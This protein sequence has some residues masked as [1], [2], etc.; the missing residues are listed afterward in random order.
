MK[1]KTLLFTSVA[2]A[3]IGVSTLFVTNKEARTQASQVVV[4]TLSIPISM[5]QGGTGNALA[6]LGSGGVVY[7]TPT[8]F[9]VTPTSSIPGAPLISNRNGA[10]PVYGPD[11]NLAYTDSS[12]PYTA[13]QSVTPKTLS[14]CT[15]S[16]AIDGISSNTYLCTLTGNII[17]QNPTVVTPGYAYTFRFQQDGTGSRLL[18]MGSYYTFQSGTPPVL[19]TA[20]NSVDYLR[21]QTITTTEIDCSNLQPG[22]AQTTTLYSMPAPS[23]YTSSLLTVEEQFN[24]ASLDSNWVGWFGNDATNRFNDAGG[25]ASPYSSTSNCGGITNCTGS[26]QQSGSYY[27]PYSYYPTSTITSGTHLMGGGGT[28]TLTAAPSTHFNATGGQLGYTWAGSAISSY[29]HI[30]LPTSGGY[31]QFSAKQP[32]SSNGAQASL[33][34][35]PGTSFPAAPEIDLMQTGYLIGNCTLNCSG[36]G[37]ASVNT[38]QFM[39]FGSTNDAYYTG[40]TDLSAG[41]HIYGLEYIPGVSLKYYLD[42]QLIQTYTTSVPS[43]NYSVIIDLQMM[44]SNTSGYHTVLSGSS[45]YNFAVRDMQIYSLPTTASASLSAPTT[46]QGNYGTGCSGTCLL[47]DDH[48]TTSTLDTSKW[49]P[50]LWINGA[51]VNASPFT[52]HANT[53]SWSPL[54]TNGA[55]EFYYDYPYLSGS[56]NYTSATFNPLQIATDGSLE[57]TIGP[58]SFFSGAGATYQS[59]AYTAKT[60]IPATGGMLQWKEKWD[61]GLQYGIW[62]TW[63]C[64]VNGSNSTLGGGNDGYS[65][66]AN[67]EIGY[68]PTPLTKVAFSGNNRTV[69]SANVSPSTDLTTYHVY[70]LEYTGDANGHT[71]NYY[72]DGTQQLSWISPYA[73]G[74]AFSCSHFLEMI[75]SNLA[76]GW[77]TQPN[78]SFPGPFHNWNTDSQVYKRPGT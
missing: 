27:D 76:D 72:I 15:G 41:Y 20:A 61:A 60:S 73:S 30:Y 6:P 34:L 28:L 11:A 21:C 67:M 71:W 44:N 46:A 39:A 57:T 16:V 53:D 31:I 33:R 78:G 12:V 65:D 62:G 26:G 36:D 52:G 45:S 5:L 8:G 77:H 37:G 63:Q 68:Q 1:I 4:S 50:V 49:F 29:G 56:T 59:A 19:S 47:M 74:L 9:G 69:G 17:I 54:G 14:P 35:L 38:L 7:G 3:I 18:S 32:D 51:L 10:Q 40:G 23:G 24:A 25:L 48:W 58:N 75:G 55:L 66:N 43:A 22:Q 70:A 42:G 2:I 13:G 64:S